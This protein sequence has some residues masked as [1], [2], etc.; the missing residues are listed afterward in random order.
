L[1]IED[2][3]ADKRSGPASLKV[4]FT[5]KVE[6]APV[7]WQWN[8]EQVKRC[9]KCSGMDY[10]FRSAGDYDVTLTVTDARGQEATLT[11]RSYIHVYG[12]R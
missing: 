12:C 9:S 4:H 8:F 2:F 5:S 11:K 10:V 6:G 7:K 1:R 3:Q